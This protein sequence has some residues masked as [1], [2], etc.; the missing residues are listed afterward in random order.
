M[1]VFNLSDDVTKRRF[2]KVE[3]FDRLLERLVDLLLGAAGV[4]EVNGLILLSQLGDF[5]PAG[6]TRV[7]HRRLVGEGNRCHVAEMQGVHKGPLAVAAQPHAFRV[8]VENPG[9]ERHRLA[10]GPRIHRHDRIGGKPGGLLG[11]LPGNVPLC[12]NKVGGR[13]LVGKADA[14]L[15]ERVVSRCKTRQTV[16][17]SL[18]VA[19]EGIPLTAARL[20][21]LRD[22]ISLALLASSAICFPN[23][24]FNLASQPSADIR[25]KACVGKLSVDAQQQAFQAFAGRFR[26]GCHQFAGLAKLHGRFLLQRL[27]DHATHP[28]KLKRCLVGQRGWSSFSGSGGVAGRFRKRACGR[29]DRG[30]YL[31]NGPQ[32]GGDGV[33]GIATKRRLGELNR[34]LPIAGSLCLLAEGSE[35]GCFAADRLLGSLK[36]LTPESRQEDATSAPCVASQL[37]EIRVVARWRRG[38]DLEAGCSG[39]G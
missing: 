10:Q 2:H 12:F 31:R 36:A 38:R 27:R 4:G 35:R 25:R 29:V 32:N 6:R 9:K 37:D 3:V 33:V 16:L 14:F 39:S 11:K 1:G 24:H 34:C 22:Q 21:T 23:P 7:E 26:I 28:F 17:L 30:A 15:D 13:L 19:E 20:F 18:E 5:L 8:V